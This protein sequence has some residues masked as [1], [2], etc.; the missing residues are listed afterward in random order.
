MA[1]LP[2]RPPPRSLPRLRLG[3]QDRGRH[4]T[5]SRI[6]P[7]PPRFSPFDDDDGQGIILMN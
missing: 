3:Q 6:S 1:T 7:P 4:P 5:T 2:A